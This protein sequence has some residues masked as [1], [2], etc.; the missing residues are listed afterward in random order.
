MSELAIIPATALLILLVWRLALNEL[1]WASRGRILPMGGR[2]RLA[3]S[4]LARRRRFPFFGWP[5][6]D[7]RALACADLLTQTGQYEEAECLLRPLLG[8]HRDIRV[9]GAARLMLAR[10]LDGQWRFDEADAES[11]SGL[12]LLENAGFPAGRL[13]LE[14]AETYR[15][16]G[17]ES[18]ALSVLR[19]AL[20][21]TDLSPAARDAISSQY[22]Y[23]CLQLRLYG[24]ALDFGRGLSE[25]SLTGP[26]GWSLAY[27]MVLAYARAGDLEKARSVASRLREPVLQAAAEAHILSAEGAHEQS[28][29]AARM[30]LALTESPVHSQ[31]RIAVVM[32]LM[33]LQR[34]EE[35]RSLAESAVSPSSARGTADVRLENAVWLITTARVCVMQEDWVAAGGYLEQAA[36]VP[37]LG[38]YLRAAVRAYHAGVLGRL[39][40]IDDARVE[41]DDAQEVV[42]RLAVDK[43]NGGEGDLLLGMAS[44]MMGEAPRA[45]QLLSQA[46]AKGLER[47]LVPAAFYHLGLAFEAQGRAG[48]AE[49]A[50]RSAVSVG[51]PDCYTTM[52]ERRLERP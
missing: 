27:A 37:R 1:Q 34:L 22:L 19:R 2:R 40:R 24:S 13:V 47:T 30:G 20:V 41:Y 18:E 29:L 21:R 46:L 50:F 28:V 35:A 43:I 44:L 49:D 48:S 26:A 5:F 32:A 17:E 52:A 9:V 45:E 11:D 42:A 14:R 8:R 15:R 16:R 3:Q 36:T 31:L 33:R 39:G 38:E 25:G 4:M 51:F 7:A 10:A 6:R 23:S 12:Q